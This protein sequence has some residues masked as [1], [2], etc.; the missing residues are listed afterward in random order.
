M[1]IIIVIIPVNGLIDCLVRIDI[2]IFAYLIKNMF[3]YKQITENYEPMVNWNCI[4]DLN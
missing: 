3:F 1:C 2:N 4:V